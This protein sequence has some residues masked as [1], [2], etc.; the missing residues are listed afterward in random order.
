MNGRPISLLLV[1]PSLIN[2]QLD[3]STGG[4][5]IMSIR[6]PQNVS[7]DFSFNVLANAPAVFLNGQAGDATN[8]PAIYRAANGLLVTASNPVRRKRFAEHLCGRTGADVAGGGRRNRVAFQSFGDGG[9][10]NP[11]LRSMASG[12][13]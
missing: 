2:A 11:R 6:T 13:P 8:L 10:C 3:D 12:F 5:A 7:P 1:S 9:G 4:P